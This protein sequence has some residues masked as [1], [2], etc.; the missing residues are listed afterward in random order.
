MIPAPFTYERATSLEHAVGLLEEHGEDAKL[1]AGGHSLLPMMKLRLAFPTVLV[2]IARLEELSY[3]RV[4]GDQLV[5]GAGTRHC[6]L[7]HAEVVRAEVPLLAEVARHIGD[8][9]ILHRGTIGGS[10]AHADAAA[11]RAVAVLAL[12]G[13]IVVAGPGGRRTIPVDEFF[14]GY[15]ETAAGP[16]EIVVEVRVPRTGSLRWGYEKF[17]R[18]AN[19]WAIVGVA[20]HGDRV[21]LANMA[22]T[23]VRATAAEQALRDGADAVAAGALASEGTDPIA[24]MNAD[25]A[26]RQHLARVLTTRVLRAAGNRA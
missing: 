21:A 12:G 19:D 22:P 20:V 10:L 25:A 26:Y 6:D 13:E 8:R 11:E 7:E 17:V 3:L 2:D 4:E 5:I 23:P 1:I 16:D 24:D 14:Q 15:F 9:Q 18:R